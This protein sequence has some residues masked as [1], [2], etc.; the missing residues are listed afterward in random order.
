MRWFPLASV[1][2]WVLVSATAMAQTQGI[3]EKV[4]T[5][6]ITGGVA[7]LSQR[8]MRIKRHDNVRLQVLSDTAGELHLHAYHA[9]VKLE[10]N[11]LTDFRFLAHA[12]GRFRLEWHPS[13]SDKSVTAGAVAKPK[14]GHHEAPVAMLEVY[15][16]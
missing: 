2:F 5:L 8:V 9:S 1:L 3:S 7:P 15:P 4:L 11:Q 6:N 12:T 16:R 14:G 10:A 13:P